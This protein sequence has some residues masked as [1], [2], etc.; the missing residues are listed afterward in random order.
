MLQELVL[1]TDAV[2]KY[3]IYK[4]NNDVVPKS[5]SQVLLMTILFQ[6]RFISDLVIQIL[7]RGI[8]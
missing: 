7:T 6:I 8:R 5:G 2:Q 3:R 1:E 4:N